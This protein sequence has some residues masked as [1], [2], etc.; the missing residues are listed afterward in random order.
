MKIARPRHD[1]AGL[2]RIDAV[3]QPMLVRG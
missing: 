1:A 3:A 2:Y